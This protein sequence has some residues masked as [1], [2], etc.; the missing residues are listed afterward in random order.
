MGSLSG[1]GVIGVVSMFT[2]IGPAV[3]LTSAIFGGSSAVYGTGRYEGT[4]FT[5]SKA[6]SWLRSSSA[7]PFLKPLHLLL[8]LAQKSIMFFHFRAINRLVDKG[9]HGE[10]LGDLESFTL[11]FSIAATPLHFATSVLNAN[12]VRGAV[13]NGRIFSNSTRLIAT[14][15]NFGTLGVDGVL[16]GFGLANLLE[17][18]KREQLTTLDV[19]QFSLSVF[20]FT[21]TLIKPQMASKIIERAQD[22][23]IQNYVDNMKDESTKN[24][25]QKFVDNN[26]GEGTMTEKSKIVRTINRIENP[27]AVFGGL[28]DATDVKIG[29]RKGRTLLVTDGSNQTKR[30]NPNK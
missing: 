7:S 24:T 22:Q 29:G 16:V 8:L 26:L 10:S 2:P 12:L 18:N 14:V 9:Q 28:K 27:D 1:C 4:C 17:K 21:N 20:F 23:H 30:I 15:L 13:T 5:I 11:W 6:F 19:L 25:F 3:L